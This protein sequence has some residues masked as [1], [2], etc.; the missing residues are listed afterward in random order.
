M[1]RDAEE[2][3]PDFD[4]LIV[5]AGISGLSAGRHLRRLLPDLRFAILEGADALGGTW[6]LHA[7]P[8]ARSDSDLY[9]FG[10][11][12]KPWMGRPYASAA[13]ILAYLEEAAEEEGLAPLIRYRNR[14][15]AAAWSEAERRWALEVEDDGERRRLS[16]RFL[17]MCQ[18]YYDH[19]R[20]HEPE[21]PGAARFP[22]PVVHPQRW[23][24]GLDIAG[25]RVAI[26]G[27]GATAATLAPALAEK[28]A[29]VTVVQRSPTY[30]YAK[31]N[32]NELA[33]MLRPLDLPPEVFHDVMRRKVIHDQLT[34]TR[35][36]FEEPEA[37]R[38]ELIGAAE[39]MLGGAAPVDPHFS[40][41][42]NP[43]RQR[44][45]V[46]PDG[47]LFT[48]IREGRVSMAT[49]AIRSFTEAGI[50]MEGGGVVA[51]DVIV[52]ATGLRMSVMGDIPFSV[53]GSPFD[54]PQAFAHRGIMFTGAPN[55]A[56]IFG[57]LRASWTLRADLVSGFVCRL[58]AHM[59]AEGREV[60]EP[61]LRPGEEGMPRRLLI[62]PENFSAG[63]IQRSIDRFPKQGDRQPW[64][65]S[66]DYED[67]RETIG[68]ARF[69]DGSLAF[70]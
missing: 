48:A 18:G 50:E 35:R 5:G 38:A 10:F 57:Y 55:L 33:A 45:A 12:W 17:W 15:R 54:F 70:C 47:D 23:P 62:E 34:F 64:L 65:F 56:W 39:A 63:Y 28:A 53:N 51:A 66:Q 20:G 19:E 42:Y 24:A 36:C 21:F 1:P 69:D 46:V 60:V 14:V 25:K 8:G 43:W 40:P 7:Y 67:E 29:H 37:V 26:V 13:E 27:S 16:C 61:R 59:Q 31:P 68:A 32:E 52:T 9:T 30:F 44:L 58:L 3:R 2:S 22:G 49:G 4:V 11:G 41:A 6:R